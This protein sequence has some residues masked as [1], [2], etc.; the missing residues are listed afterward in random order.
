MHS[1]KLEI[2]I[3]FICIVLFFIIFLF[4][5]LITILK[6]SLNSFIPLLHNKDILIATKNSIEV[7]A[8]AAIITTIVAFILAYA[9]NCTNIFKFLSLV[10]R[11][12][13]S[14]P[15]LLPTITYGFAIIYSFG[16]QGFLTKIFGRQ[17]FEIYGFNG[18]LLGYVI[19]TIP[20]AFLLINNSFGYIDKRFMTISNLM[21]DNFLRSFI[22]NIIRPLIGTFG[23]ALVLTFI[24]SFTDFGIPTS[25]G[26]N[27]TVIS[28][29]L[30]Q[31][32]LGAIPDFNSG[33]AIAVIMLFPSIIGIIFLSYLE[34]F[35]FHYD[36]F[37]KTVLVKNRFRDI[38]F[39]AI[40]ILTI[41]AIASVFLVMFI[42]PFAVNYPY[43]MKFTT[44]YLIEL[45]SSSQNIDVYINS[46]FVSIISAV[47]G[48]IIS[49]IAAL[50]NVRTNS[51]KIVTKSIDVFSMVTNTVPGM[52]L[53]LSYLMFF[54]NSDLKGTFT[55][56]IA[57]NIIHLFTTPYLMAKNS[58][59]KMNPAFETTGE[60]MGDTWIK[61]VIRVIIPNSISTIIEMFGYYFINSMV[62]ISAII[63]LVSA[64]TAL[65][66]SK[67]QE[68]Q[69]FQ[70]FNQIFLLSIIIFITNIVIKICCEIANKKNSIK[71]GEIV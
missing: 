53:G 38:S 4:A 66:T 61:T 43:N 8:I 48:V 49:Y 70:N 60:L 52:V 21:G 65:M 47:I 57:C 15:M 5:P 13:I 1:K 63:F 2:K 31:V 62:T 46:L 6:N 19:Y 25:V 51:R 54:N 56:I 29:M 36:K 14:V 64:G 44:K 67:I 59:S 3:I 30:Y 10:I 33:S 41:L 39:G 22:N 20:F 12:G 55:I 69:Y 24:L 71:K 50:I 35:N 40:S 28:T 68:L 11:V 9:V 16:K 18:L 23:G 7:S 32:M 34:K 27:Y 26:G 17:L 58:L 42:A 37:T 45:F